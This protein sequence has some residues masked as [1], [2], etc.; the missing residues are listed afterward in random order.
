MLRRNFLGAL[1]AAPAIVRA[2]SLDGLA[3]LRP[4]PVAAPLII[5][6]DIRGLDFFVSLSDGNIIGPL[7]LPEPMSFDTFEKLIPKVHPA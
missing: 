5:S 6:L 2:S 4:A 3:F 7:K 1:L